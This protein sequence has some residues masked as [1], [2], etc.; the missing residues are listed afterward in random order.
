[1]T[2]RFEYGQARVKDLAVTLKNVQGKPAVDRVLIDGEPF[3]PSARFWNSL[4]VR[5]GF[6]A[7]IFRYFRHEEVFARISE[8]ASNDR[9]RWCAERRGDGPG[10][11]LAV[12]NPTAPVMRHDDL[13]GLLGKNGAEEVNYHNGVVR[14]R[15]TPRYGAPFDIAGDA[16][17]NKY[18]ID[19]PIDGYGR[20]V[21]Y[22][23]L[24]RQICTNGA[25]AHTPVF[26]SELSLGRGEHGVG[27]ALVRALD[28]FNNE[29]GYSALRQR[30]EAA[31]R[32][33]ASV[34]EATELYRTLVRLHHADGVA[35]DIPAVGT[36][37]AREPLLHAFH[38]M[39]GD[40]T[41]L[42]GLANLDALSVKRQR[43]LPTRAK[44]YDLL[45]FASEIATHH[46][47][48]AAARGLHAF[49]GDLISTE[50]DLEGTADHFGDWKDFFVKN[51]ATTDTLAEM[52][53]R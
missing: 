52:Q 31:T 44:V 48:P 47:E 28:G 33:W 50:Y 18:V 43:T 11:L 17:Q 12:T 2:Q 8:V 30:F 41:R 35:G 40:L 16:F 22:L 23:S 3:R 5:F 14:S 45:N 19:T 37:G 32:S 13:M 34:R 46:A 26:R 25:V 1:M 9:L 38:R 51:E 4:Q 29:E 27:F 15:H 6:T 10:T 20:P 36:D 39:T 7:N 53:R 49:V 42:Y 24:L 21:V